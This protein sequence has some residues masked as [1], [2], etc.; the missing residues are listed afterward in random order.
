[1][2]VGVVGAK[3]KPL[4]SEGVPRG[5]GGKTHVLRVQP[6]TRHDSKM[7]VPGVP[8]GPVKYR[9]GKQL[10]GESVG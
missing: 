2:G 5:K 7:R 4:C 10:G 9:G 6:E 8:A 3:G 1:M